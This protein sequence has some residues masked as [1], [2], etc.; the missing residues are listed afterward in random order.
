[1]DD[2]VRVTCTTMYSVVLPAV[3]VSTYYSFPRTTVIIPANRFAVNH[4]MTIMPVHA[5]KE[6]ERRKMNTRRPINI[7]MVMVANVM[8]PV[9]W[10]SSM[11]PM[12]V[13]NQWVVVGYVD[14]FPLTRLNVNYFTSRFA[15][16]FNFNVVIGHQV[17][18][19]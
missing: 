16:S 8:T 1:M 19:V 4:Y 17:T 13:Y 5:T 15:F 7:A 3:V 12:A 6:K 2:A 11:P 9:H 14:H 18:G 10:G